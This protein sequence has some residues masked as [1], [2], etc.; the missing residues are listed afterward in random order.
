MEDSSRF[1]PELAS[2]VLPAPLLQAL[3]HVFAQ[4]LSDCVLVGGTALAGFYAGHRRSDD[5]DLFA[6]SATAF[7]QAVLAVRSLRTIEVELEERSHSN[8]YFRAVCYHR[9]LAF[10]VD[11]VLDEGGVSHHGHSVTRKTV[12]TAHGAVHGGRHRVSL[13]DTNTAGDVVVAG[14][15]ALLAMKAAALVSRC[16]EKDLYD[17]LWL[18]DAFPEREL[19]ELIELG[20]TVDRGVTGE[21]LIYSIGSTE[22]DRAAC[23]FAVEFGTSAATVYSRISALRRELLTALDLHLSRNATSTLREVVRRVRRL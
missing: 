7:T 20:R 8:Q 3:R 15:P 4:G 9:Q 21:T 17:L 19:A 1:D 10:T 11:V 5:L 22:L 18:F 23:T 2:R 16:S 13:S 14:L 12:E 6:G